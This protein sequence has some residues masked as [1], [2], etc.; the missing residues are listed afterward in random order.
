[1]RVV[2]LS[3]HG[4]EQLARSQRQYSD[5]AANAAAWQGYYAQSLHDADAARRAKPLLKR[6]LG[7][8]TPEEQAARARVGEAWQHAAAAGSGADRAY[9]RVQQQG[10]G[11]YG[12][13]LLAWCLSG[14]SDEWVLLRGYRN[15]RGETDGVLVGPHGVWAIEIKRRQVAVARGRR[16]LVVSE[17]QREG[18][19]LRARIRRRRRRP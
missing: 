15:R 9:G 7:T 16:A 17:D 5:A 8:T 12:E 10:A 14:L 6:I 2:V 18:S 3:D 11:A 1:M 19:P 13:D 4:G